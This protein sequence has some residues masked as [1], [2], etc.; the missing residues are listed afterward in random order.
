[1]IWFLLMSWDM[2]LRWPHGENA[3]TQRQNPCIN[4]RFVHSRGKSPWSFS[5]EQLPRSLSKL[6]HSEKSTYPGSLA[7]L[8]GQIMEGQRP[9]EVQKGL[10]TTWKWP[11]KAEAYASLQWDMCMCA[12]VGEEG[13]EAERRAG[14]KGKRHQGSSQEGSAAAK[15]VGIHSALE[16]K[17]HCNASI[18]SKPTALC[19][20]PLNMHFF[21]FSF[22]FPNTKWHCQTQSCSKDDSFGIF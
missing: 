22:T 19:Q 7:R 5:W 12:M 11:H 3:C 1:M 2:C 8:Q 9:S 21:F 18:T 13:V 15:Q 17:S 6:P 20:E 10:Q 14:E 4:K 16:E